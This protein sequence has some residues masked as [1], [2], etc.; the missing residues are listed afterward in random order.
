MSPTEFVN[1]MASLTPEKASEWFKAHPKT[2]EFLDIAKLEPGRVLISSHPDEVVRHEHGYGVNGQRPADYLESFR[3]FVN[4]NRDTIAALKI[5]TQRPRELTRQTLKEL[6]LA[7]QEAG[8]NETHLQT[9]W[10]DTR[11]EDIAATIIGYVRHVMMGEALC[12]YKERV[13]VAMKTILAS[14][15]WTPPQR[16]WLE[17]IGKQLE[18]E[19][20]V[21]RQAFDQGQFQAEGGFN[22]LNKVFNG[23]LEAILNQIAETI[24]PVA[25]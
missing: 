7:L 4:T 8:Y 17:R 25:A 24:W 2:P 9:A 14:R 20:V 15:P 3:D 22:R 16:K 5:V 19:T 21:D 12:P 23:E 11:N 6:K 18:T 10:R 13:A 1:H